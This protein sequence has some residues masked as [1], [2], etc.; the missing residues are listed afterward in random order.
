M[1]TN[2][3]LGILQQVVLRKEDSFFISRL[4]EGLHKEQVNVSY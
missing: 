2:C 3:K 4:S 1:G